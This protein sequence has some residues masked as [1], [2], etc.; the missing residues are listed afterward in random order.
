MSSAKPTHRNRGRH[1]P[2]L[3]LPPPHPRACPQ[4]DQRMRTECLRQA[5]RRLHRRDQRRT[6]Q[7]GRDRVDTVGTQRAE[8]DVA[9]E[10]LIHREQDEGV[11]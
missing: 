4:R 9:G 11:D 1:R 2:Y 7:G 6:A 10:G 5:Q 3:P 8:D